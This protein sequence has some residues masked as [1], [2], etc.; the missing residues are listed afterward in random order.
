MKKILLSVLCSLSA[1]LAF[2]QLNMTLS[3][4]LNYGVFVSSLWGYIDPEDSTE[5][6]AVGVSTGLSIVDLSNPN[7]VQEIKFIPDVTSQ[8]RE[9]KSWG[10]YIYA[11]TEGGGGMLVVNMTNPNNITSTHWAPNIPGLGTLNKIHSITVDEFGFLYLNGS[12]LNA[13]G[14]L[15]VDVSAD[16]GNPVYVGKL[17]AIYCH[18]SYARN[19]IFY[20]S[21]IFA[22]DFKVYDVTNKANPVLLAT[23][24]TPF[25]FTHNTWLNDAGDV[26]F[27]TD[28]KANAP[29]G[30]YDISDLDN[31]VELDQFRPVSTI[32]L[33]TIPHNVHVWNDWVV[34][35][36]YTN[37]TIIIDGSRPQNMIEVGNFDSFVSQT[38]GFYG[39][40][41]VYP[42]FPSGV[43]I[44]S[45]M[46]NGLLVYDV[47]Y[48]RA[49]WLE[50]KVTNAITGANVSGVSVSIASTQA[51]A[52]TTDLSGNYKTGQAIPGV[53][54]VTF[55]ATGYFPKTVQATLQNGVLTIL[56][57]ALE[58][59]TISQFPPFSYTGTT[60]GCA[61]ISVNFAENSG[62]VA[63]WEWTFTNGIPATS[64]DQNPIVSYT[65]SGTHP[66]SLQVVTQ[67]GNTYTLN[68]NVVVSVVPA[69]D[70]A[71]TSTTS[72]YTASFA[73][74]SQQFS[75]L[76]W[77]FGDGGTSTALNPQHTYA[78]A[79][80]YTVT[81]TVSGNCGTDVATQQVVIGPFTP[82]ADFGATP[83]VGCAPLSVAFADL[84]TNGPT[85]WAW[86]LQGG[87]PSFSTLQN[88]TVSYANPGSYNVQ[89]TAANAAGNDQDFESAFITVLESPVA[90]FDPTIDGPEALFVNT[91][92]GSNVTYAWNFGDGQ[93]SDEQN[94]L[95]IYAAAGTYNVNLSVTNTCG[96]STYS[97]V[98][99]IA[100]FLPSANFSTNITAGCAPLTVAYTDQS[101]GQ[102]T[103]YLWTFNGGNPATSNL[104]NPVV[105]YNSPGTYAAILTVG[106]TWGINELSQNDLIT[107]NGP[108]ASAFSFSIN[109]NMV[110]FT[111]NSTNATDYGW[112]FNDGSGNTST[113]IHPSYDF[114]GPGTYNVT[115]NATNACGT[116]SYSADVTISAV[117]PTAAFSTGAAQGC[118]PLQVQF[119]DLS[120]NAPTAWSW[121]F[122]G[123]T[124][125]TSTQQNPLV[126]YATPGVYGATLIASNSAGM[127]EAAQAGIITVL[128]APQSSFT[129]A[130]TD[131]T[132]SF[133]NASI[134]TG[135]LTYAWTFGDSGTST[136]ANPVHTFAENGTYTVLLVVTDN[137]GSVALAQDVVIDVPA[138]TV[139]FDATTPG[140]CAPA[141]VNFT[142]MST[143]LISAYAWSFPGGD[144]AISSEENPTVTYATPGVYS[145][146]LAVT[147]PGGTTTMALPDF[148][149]VVDVPQADFDFAVN[150][151]EASFNSTTQ[152]ATSLNWDFG[153]G[154][155]TSTAADP[156]YSYAEPGSYEVTLTATNSCG[157]VETTQTVTIMPSAI[158]ETNGLAALLSASPNPFSE[159]VLVSY[160]LEK[161]F[162]K[163][164]ILATNALGAT[165][166]E[167]PVQGQLGTIELG[168]ELNGS[169]V[170]FLRLVVDGQVA[171]V[172][173]VVRI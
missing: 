28:E 48:V 109:G 113:A 75:S 82:V 93:T 43:V 105:T 65:S 23:Q 116:T 92:T 61:P 4:Q 139:D 161:Q 158:G 17:P 19:N 38:A 103:S 36:Y 128:G 154:D 35:A 21:D 52:A 32:G 112:L 155:G 148:L 143:G 47:N 170:F 68:S 129:A 83:T 97:Q 147:G 153:D 18:D 26:I 110:S 67:G 132:V 49:C 59:T 80:N 145:M 10:H 90:G 87:S 45:D 167:L 53:F 135:T 14:S 73:N 8:W 164:S 64:P 137:C 146:E 156:T 117:A 70:A 12:N 136:E 102:P 157:T 114:P 50:G 95:H 15:I 62:I 29:V 86:S 133:T 30:V 144:P 76:V 134:G 16:N 66:V 108:P 42:Y 7:D 111:N 98:I 44:A 106:N 58:P 5:Y 3:D 138:P 55:T 88:P 89:L 165:V 168:E 25:N 46:Q 85:A 34:T 91:S 27:T 104:T 84:S 119:T 33:G 1:F 51:N 94:P 140:F 118:S 24:Q 54:N 126:T 31:I 141:T 72:G 71:F 159:R 120:A 99:T 81:L 41:G 150:E 151:M 163:A 60:A 20:S 63:S 107:V 131:L 152:N 100:S 57:V 13:G 171:G 142:D 79:G 149:T 162:E 22:G 121:S 37:G 101:T 123:G 6:A 122:P 125:A 160:Q 166:A 130:V 69:Q 2:A 39:V 74:T 115:L 56:D 124:P 77:N 78:Q 172:L 11:V 173:R 127:S 40:W 169:G 96:T 9:V